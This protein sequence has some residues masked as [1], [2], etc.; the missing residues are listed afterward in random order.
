MGIRECIK[1]RTVP[2]FNLEIYQDGSI[3]EK[4][5]DM[6][7]KVNDAIHHGILPEGFEEAV[8]R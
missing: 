2:T 6:F 5:L 3:S 7:K 8:R 1:Y 4:T